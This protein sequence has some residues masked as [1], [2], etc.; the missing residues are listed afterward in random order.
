M[1]CHTDD[2]QTTVNSVK[3][4]TVFKTISFSEFKTNETALN[5]LEKTSLERGLSKKINDTINGFYYDDTQIIVAEYDNIKTYTFS[6][7][8]NK[9]TTDAVIENLVI[10]VSPENVR[11]YIFQYTFT[12]ADITNVEQNLSVTDLHQKTF[13][14]HANG[15]PT[16]IYR[17]ADGTCWIPTYWGPNG[18]HDG[19]TWWEL[20]VNCPS[21]EKP[22]NQTLINPDNPGSGGG[23]GGSCTSGNIVTI[24]PEVPGL[25]PS[26]PGRPRFYPGGGEDEPV[27]TTPII[28]LGLQYF[29][30]LKKRDRDAYDYLVTHPEIKDKIISFLG[31]NRTYY[32]DKKILVDK[33]I[34]FAIDDEDNEDIVLQILEY[35]EKYGDLEESLETA[36]KLIDIAIDGNEDYVRH[37]LDYCRN[38]NT[39][40]S[41]DDTL[42]AENSLT[43]D[44][45]YDVEE[46]FTISDNNG[47]VTYE[48]NIQEQQITATVN[49]E[50]SPLFD[51]KID[52][53]QKLQ[54]TY[55]LIEVNTSFTG[56]TFGNEWIQSNT[57]QPVISGNTA[58]IKIRGIR[59]TRIK[60]LDTEGVIN[61]RGIVVTI[62]LNKIT[63]EVI[64]KSI[65]YQ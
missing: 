8:R 19:T 56:F 21:D 37:L 49:F 42:N 65:V 15:N 24:I 35:I 32:I 3:G 55:Q 46:Y 61:E 39:N 36:I 47:E 28:N 7:Y 22:I 30:G 6:I 4:G 44:N 5:E 40:I 26:Q 12:D 11:S 1:S 53:D 14:T 48:T 51:L 31:I 2:D 23:G 45:F 57:P 58:T 10:R 62:V 18:E 27:V 52:I 43:F 33:I 13:V 34:E 60:I 16:G 59:K 20:T 25:G 29:N 64:S 9:P 50:M 41:F 63:V 54:P 17:R 38:T